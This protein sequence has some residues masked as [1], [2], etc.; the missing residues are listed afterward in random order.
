MWKKYQE[1]TKNDPPSP[2]LVEALEYVSKP[3]VALDFGSGGLKDSRY[4][5]EKGFSVFALDKEFPD[6]PN[7]LG[8][9]RAEG[10]FEEAGFGEASAVLINAQFS[11]PFIEHKEFQRIFNDLYESLQPGG[12]FV[13]N[14][15]GI[16]DD[17]AKEGKLVFHSKEEVLRLLKS[18]QITLF[19]EEEYDKKPAIGGMKHWHV[20]SFI[21]KKVY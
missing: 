16:H 5:A 10:A 8:I 12:I 7:D 21:A 19:R 4:L 14:L 15:F 1:L 13:G 17:W 11:L 9:I 20:F 6:I 2:L 3:G 18:Y